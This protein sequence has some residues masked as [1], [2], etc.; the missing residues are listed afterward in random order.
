MR[1]P[2]LIGMLPLRITRTEPSN[3]MAVDGTV[4]GTTMLLP[5]G[6]MPVMATVVSNLR[7]AMPTLLA[8]AAK[9]KVIGAGRPTRGPLAKMVQS[10]L[11]ASTEQVGAGGPS[12]APP[13][14][15]NTGAGGL[16]QRTKVGSHGDPALG[17]Q[18]VLVPGALENM[19]GSRPLQTPPAHEALLL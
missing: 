13:V 11:A 8:V 6:S 12:A 5:A 7:S 4:G 10:T 14:R 3:A 19:T 15:A 9:V 2:P 16:T 17:V 18:G 1:L